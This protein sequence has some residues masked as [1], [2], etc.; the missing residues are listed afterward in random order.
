MHRFKFGAAARAYQRR[1]KGT[2][3]TCESPL[4]E[5]LAKTIRECSNSRSAC[6]LLLAAVADPGSVR[7]DIVY[8]SRFVVVECSTTFS[9]VTDTTKLRACASR[10]ARMH[11]KALRD[12]N[13]DLTNMRD[14]LAP[15]WEALLRGSDRLTVCTV[16]SVHQERFATVEYKVRA[17]GA[18]S[19]I[20]WGSG[21]FRL[22]APAAD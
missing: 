1:A 15:D 6:D 3:A 20:L 14:H 4:A 10:L 7:T 16:A 12:S 9:R 13:A 17:D 2:T 5:R 18:G 21:V 8:K 22:W 19:V 11:A